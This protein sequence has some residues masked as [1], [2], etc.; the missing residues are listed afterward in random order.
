MVVIQ[1]EGEPFPRRKAP[2]P[3]NYVPQRA[4]NLPYTAV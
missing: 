1:W 4:V 2:Y 3:C